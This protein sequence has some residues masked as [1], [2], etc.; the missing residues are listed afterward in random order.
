MRLNISQRTTD[1]VLNFIKYSRHQKPV[2][3]SA[4]AMERQLNQRNSLSDPNDFTAA[5]QGS[6]AV[7]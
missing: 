5:S 6:I 7:V 4:K 1:E 3:L 2:P